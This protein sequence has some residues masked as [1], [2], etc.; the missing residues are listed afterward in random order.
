MLLLR[1]VSGQ[2][3]LSCLRESVTHVMRHAHGDVESRHAEACVDAV[4]PAFG[5]EAARRFM[6]QVYSYPPLA[7]HPDCR[8]FDNH[9]LRIGA[10]TLCL[11][12]TCAFCGV[13][14]AVVGLVYVWSRHWEWMQGCGPAG[15]L[16]GGVTLFAPTLAQPFVQVKPFKMAARFTLGVAVVALWFGGMVMLPL[17][18]A[19]FCLR[20]VFVGIFMG[21]YRATLW[22]RARYAKDPCRDCPGP[23]YPLCQDRRD[24]L[25]PLIV[26]LEAVARPEDAPFIMFA[27][28]LAGLGDDGIDVECA[29]LREGILAAVPGNHTGSPTH[30]MPGVFVCCHTERTRG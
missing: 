17:T 19:G 27:R 18:P 22:Q 23:R 4:R 26:E 24:R 29:D 6:A 5:S 2:S 10:L 7:H 20:L 9:V 8:C 14:T 28:A 25:Q 13:A 21:V 12:C 3:Y 16:I 30:V 11:G 15:F 1:E